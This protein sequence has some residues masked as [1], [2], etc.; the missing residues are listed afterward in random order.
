MNTSSIK[1][2]TDKVSLIYEFDKNSPLFAR[3]ASKEIDAGNYDNAVNILK[4]GLKVFPGHPVAFILLGRAFSLLGDYDQAIK[5]YKEGSEFINSPDTLEYYN[6]ELVNLK[7]QKS[8]YAATRRRVFLNKG[9]EFRQNQERDGAVK[10]I[11][12]IEEETRAIEDRLEQLAEKISTAKIRRKLGIEGETSDTLYE[13]S[14]K[15]K[16]ISETLAG[17]Y[18]SQG[19]FHEAIKVYEK[20]IK[21][22]P[23]KEDYFTE[24][25][26]EIHS[27]FEQ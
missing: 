9:L 25:I 18:L 16:I 6:N 22:K 3:A 27:R 17:I 2:L 24:K 12:G 7:K 15:N 14:E 4:R 13:L 20:L 11:N 23:E 1:D 5:Y 19:E 26:K 10:E 21:S 8:L